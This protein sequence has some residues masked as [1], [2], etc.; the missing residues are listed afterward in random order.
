MKH[1]VANP[2]PSLQALKKAYYTRHY[3]MPWDRPSATVERETLENIQAA[4]AKRQEQ[5]KENGR[6]ATINA[7]RSNALQLKKVNQTLADN[8]LPPWR[9]LP[10]GDTNLEIH[11]KV[12]YEI[13]RNKM[14]DD[15]EMQRNRVR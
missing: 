1:V 10:P 7:E 2:P 11:G 8:G 5:V 3:L 4:E 13:S 15:A 6:V 9:S 14:Q 12:R